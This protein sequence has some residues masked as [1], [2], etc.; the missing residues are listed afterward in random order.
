MIVLYD[1][2]LLAAW[3]PMAAA[4]FTTEVF[5]WLLLAN[6]ADAFRLYNLA[7]S[8]ATAAAAGIGGAANTIPAAQALASIALWPLAASPRRGRRLPK[9]DPM[10]RPS[11][12]PAALL[13]LAACSEE[14]PPTCPPRSP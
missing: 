14:R 2:G 13:A 6:P 4:R 5:P 8:E 1:L 9:G 11:I 3:S 7:A 10:K 12:I